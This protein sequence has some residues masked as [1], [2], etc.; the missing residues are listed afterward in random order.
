MEHLI[1][2]ERLRAQDG[3]RWQWKIDMK[4]ILICPH[5]QVDGMMKSISSCDGQVWAVSEDGGLWYRANVSLGTPM[6]SNWFR[7][8][9]PGLELGWR[10]V[11]CRDGVM[12]AVDGKEGLL[13]R[14]NVSQDNIEGK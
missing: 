2:Q 9:E 6:G 1:C 13:V 5:V 12:W 7:V 11:A 8:E 3:P 14:C 4:M 10:T